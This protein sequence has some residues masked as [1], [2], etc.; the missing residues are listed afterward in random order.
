MASNAQPVEEIERKEGGAVIVGTIHN[1]ID[2]YTTT[3]CFE[4][5]SG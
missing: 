2:P 3:Q 1:G 5:V 4:V